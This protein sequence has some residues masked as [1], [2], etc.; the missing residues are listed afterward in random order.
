LRSTGLVSSWSPFSA[1]GRSPGASALPQYYRGIRVGLSGYPEKIRR[2]RGRTSFIHP[3]RLVPTLRAMHYPQLLEP[4]Y[5][6]P[7]S[8]RHE[9]LKPSQAAPDRLDPGLPSPLRARKPPAGRSAAPPPSSRERIPGLVRP[10]GPPDAAPASARAATPPRTTPRGG[11]APGRSAR[12]AARP[13]PRTS[14]TPA[15]AARRSPTAGRSIR[16]PLL[17]T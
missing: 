8:T 16:Q 15:P 12:A 13:P 7:V 3:L 17:S 2:G 10:T 6:L 1:R 9:G 11:A 14:P 4:G 5:S